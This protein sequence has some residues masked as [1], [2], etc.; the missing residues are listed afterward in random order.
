ML[1][2]TEKL[3]RLNEEVIIIKQ[4][5]LFFGF[6]GKI[7]AHLSGYSTEEKDGYYRVKVKT[8]KRSQST[9][10]YRQLKSEDIILN[11]KICRYLYG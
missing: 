3:F 10:Q 8:N 1:N 5:D 11:S 7:T 4:E 2:S 9:F 6:V